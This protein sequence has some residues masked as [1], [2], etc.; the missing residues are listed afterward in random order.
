M[1]IGFSN[2]IGLLCSM[3]GDAVSSIH[4]GFGFASSSLGREGLRLEKRTLERS[5]SMQVS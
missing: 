4:N 5:G 1:D 3:S 2:E